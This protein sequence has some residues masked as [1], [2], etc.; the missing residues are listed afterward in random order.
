MSRTSRLHPYFRIKW[1]K[2]TEKTAATIRSQAITC[3][4]LHTYTH[5]RHIFLFD[6]MCVLMSMT[7]PAAA[8]V[9]INTPIHIHTHKY[10]HI[11]TCCTMRLHICIQRSCKPLKGSVL[12]IHQQWCYMQKAVSSGS[13]LCASADA[14]NIRHK[15]PF[16]RQHTHT[17]NVLATVRQ[18]NFDGKNCRSLWKINGDPKH[19]VKF[20]GSSFRLFK[21]LILHSN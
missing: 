18:R 16:M 1:G 21:V 8:L 7:M 17:S 20:S 5:K 14:C 4:H 13:A 9:F 15:C 6:C 3:T 12:L 10:I 2:R 19:Q 11:Y